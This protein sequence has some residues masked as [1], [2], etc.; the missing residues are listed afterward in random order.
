MKTLNKYISKWKPWTSP[1][2]IA[3]ALC[4]LQ[5]CC[6]RS[7]SLHSLF[8][9]IHRASTHF[10]TCYSYQ[11]TAFVDGRSWPP[12]VCGESLMLVRSVC[13]ND[14]T[15]W[16]LNEFENRYEAVYTLMSV[17]MR[18][19]SGF[20]GKRDCKMC[21]AFNLHNIHTHTQTLF[22]AH[23]WLLQKKNCWYN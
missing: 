5:T 7:E 13:I 9:I 22:V 12:M 17:K 16:I 14:G 8:H 20:Q 21:K 19:C 18:C 6:R 3:A 11:L 23:R 2:S 4:V 10:I 1:P 15:R